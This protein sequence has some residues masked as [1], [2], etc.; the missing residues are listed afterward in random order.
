MSALGHKQTLEDVN[1]MSALSPKGDIRYPAAPAL[2]LLRMDELRS[3]SDLELA[4][5]GNPGSSVSVGCGRL[6]RNLC[7]GSEASMWKILG[8]D[9]IWAGIVWCHQN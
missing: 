2:Q 6:C 8:N 5:T 1:A 3:W 7:M 9:R 4:P